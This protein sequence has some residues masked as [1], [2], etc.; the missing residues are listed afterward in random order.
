MI[1]TNKSSNDKK[2]FKQPI[3]NYEDH[4][5]IFFKKKCTYIVVCLRI[6]CQIE[7]YH[8]SIYAC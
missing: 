2:H 5:A 4:L 6:F 8:L 1:S 7:P 3:N